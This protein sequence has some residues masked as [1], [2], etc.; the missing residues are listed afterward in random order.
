MEGTQTAPPANQA[1]TTEQKLFEGVVT[2]KDGVIK[3]DMNKLNDDADTAVEIGKVLGGK[4][5]GETSQRVNAFF[6]AIIQHVNTTASEVRAKKAAQP[7]NPVDPT[8]PQE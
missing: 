3:I 2:S 6:G 5:V 4:I 7:T 8:P 1:Q